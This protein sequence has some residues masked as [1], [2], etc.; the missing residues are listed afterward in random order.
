MEEEIKTKKL[1]DKLDL[2]PLDWI[3]LPKWKK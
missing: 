3:G 1:A 2:D